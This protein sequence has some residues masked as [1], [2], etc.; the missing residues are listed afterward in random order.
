MAHSVSTAIDQKTASVWRIESNASGRLIASVLSSDEVTEMAT[1]WQQCLDSAL[2]STAGDH[3]VFSFILPL[4]YSIQCDAAEVLSCQRCE[5]F[6]FVSVRVP[7][8]QTYWAGILRAEQD[9]GKISLYA[10]FGCAHEAF[11]EE[12]VAA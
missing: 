9:F 6:A 7:N 1:T 3:V 4:D 10:P 8:S 12:A 2:E 11:V 5:N